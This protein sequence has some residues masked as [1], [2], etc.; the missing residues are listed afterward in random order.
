MANRKITALRALF[1][2]FGYGPAS[3]YSSNSV[4]GTL[5]EFAVKAEVVSSTKKI[6][7]K[8]MAE[9]LEWI[10]KNKGSETHEPFDLTESKTHAT[11]TYK[12]NGNTITAGNDVLYNGDVLVVTAEA[13]TG[14]EITTLTANG[15]DIESGDDIVIN[16]EGI[17]IV[18]TATEVEADSQEE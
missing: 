3:D 8:T 2:A 1:A 18:A 12:L 6:R 15:D 4:A 17:A 5:K 16:G 14:Y 13:D 7:A 11:V 10:V 9:V